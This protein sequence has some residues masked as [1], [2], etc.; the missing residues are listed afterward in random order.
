[1][2]VTYNR[3]VHASAKNHGINKQTVERMRQHRF[4]EALPPLRR[5]LAVDPA[6]WNLWYMAGRCCRY[7]ND[8]DGAVEHLRRASRMHKGFAPR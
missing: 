3:H 2:P 4:G 5:V 7:A 1:M 6:Q 8:I